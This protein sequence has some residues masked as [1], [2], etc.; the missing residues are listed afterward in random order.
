MTTAER[1]SI[2][3]FGYQHINVSTSLSSASGYGAPPLPPR[4]GKGLYNCTKKLAC[5]SLLR[6]IKGPR[7][8]PNIQTY[9]PSFDLLLPL[10]SYPSN[11][12]T[13]GSRSRTPGASA[14][15]GMATG[16]TRL[17]SD[18]LTYCYDSRMV[19]V[20]RGESY[21]VRSFLPSFPF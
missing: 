12:F 3:V 13:V 17:P 18:I 14:T 9:L 5:P 21:D 4:I 15:R 8:L 19:Y 2:A 16:T 6:A 20:T 10:M 1:R 7:G 11:A